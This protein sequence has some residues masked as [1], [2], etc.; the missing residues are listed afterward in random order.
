MYRYSLSHANKDGIRNCQKTTI[1]FICRYCV[2][3][4]A[5]IKMEYATHFVHH[6]TIFPCFL[7]LRVQTVFFIIFYLE[8]NV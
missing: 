1:K 3:F 4:Q 2:A 8:V 5:N 6:S 7:L